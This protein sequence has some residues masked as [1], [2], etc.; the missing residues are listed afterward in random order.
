MSARTE[1]GQ[2]SL[3]LIA[4]VP[5]LLLLALVL[6]QLLAVGY[7]ATLA[8]NAAEAGSLARAS[9]R[10][11][12]KAAKAAVPGWSRANMRVSVDKGEVEVRMRPPSPIPAVAKALEVDASASTGR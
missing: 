5:A 9:E 1:G 2:A 12:E 8:G 7:S 3:E 6:L 4:A 10:D 11:A